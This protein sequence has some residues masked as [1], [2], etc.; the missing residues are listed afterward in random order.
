MKEIVIKQ[1]ILKTATM[2][3]VS[4]IFAVGGMFLFVD[5]NTQN[6]IVGGVL[7]IFSALGAA[8][9]LKSLVEQKPVLVINENEFI[10]DVYS[11]SWKYVKNISIKK[12]TIYHAK[13]LPILKKS[14]YVDLIDGI[15]ED[16]FFDKKESEVISALHDIMYNL[17]NLNK[18][19]IEI[20]I[21]S[22][23]SKP[24]NVLQIMQEYLESYRSNTAGVE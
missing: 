16:Y 5:N 4:L 22:A 19:E 20:D 21:S 3:L 17:L 23:W 13:G 10:Y 7:A 12:T 15:N 9:I 18:S 2:L 11:V 24:E 14:I 1:S 8:V 6:K